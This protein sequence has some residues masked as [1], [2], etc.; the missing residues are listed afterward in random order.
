MQNKSIQTED[1]LTQK[2]LYYISFSQSYKDYQPFKLHRPTGKSNT[3]NHYINFKHRIAIQNS[4]LIALLNRY[5][6]IT[7]KSIGKISSSHRNSPRI[8]SLRKDNDIIDLYEFVKDQTKQIIYTIPLKKTETKYKE[9]NLM[10]KRKS[11]SVLLLSSNFIIDSLREYGFFFESQ[12]GYRNQNTQYELI[13][14]IYYNGQLLFTKD[15]I[16]E[17]GEQLN[18]YFM[19]VLTLGKQYRQSVIFQENS[20]ILNQFIKE[21][22]PEL[23]SFLITL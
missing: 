17:F 5:F 11:I 13:E 4:L 20:F 22:I 18:D 10:K 15:D 12:Y 23:Y 9:L 8:E 2:T 19:Y 7:F 21:N 1:I 6:T 3:L 16:Y 14:N